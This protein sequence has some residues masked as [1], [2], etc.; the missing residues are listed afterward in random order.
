MEA[1]CEIGHILDIQ[2]GSIAHTFPF[3]VQK[4]ARYKNLLHALKCSRLCKLLL[5]NITLSCIINVKYLSFIFL[6]VFVSFAVC[7]FV[8]LQ[9]ETRYVYC[10]RSSSGA[11]TKTAMC[12]MSCKEQVAFVAFVHQLRTSFPTGSGFCFVTP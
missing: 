11:H 1:Q 2:V 12:K 4:S 10:I 8:I 3:R 5:K 6:F 9:R 7:L